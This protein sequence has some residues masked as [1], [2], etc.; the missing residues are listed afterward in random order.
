MKNS[1]KYFLNNLSVDSENY[2]LHYFFD[3]ENFNGNNYIYNNTE[4]TDYTGTY[5]GSNLT[6][7]L[8]K[9]TGYLFFDT[10]N[11]VNIPLKDLELGSY[12]FIVNYEKTGNGPCVLF[13]NLNTGIGGQYYGFNVCISDYNNLLIEYY[14]VN[15]NLK[16]LSPTY[17]LDTKGIVSFRGYENNI[18]I[19]YYNA[20]YD[21][22][23]T[24]AFE[25]D[26]NS[27]PNVTGSIVLGSGKFSNFPNYSGYIRDFILI[28]DNITNS[29][30]NKIIDQFAFN[31][32]SYY[33]FQRNNEFYG[34]EN[35]P[36]NVTH[37]FDSYVD[38]TG[39]FNSGFLDNTGVIYGSI[40]GSNYSLDLT[41]NSGVADVLYLERRPF[42]SLKNKIKKTQIFAFTNTLSRTS[43]VLLNDGTI[44]GWGRNSF[45][46]LS[47]SIDYIGDWT[48][49]PVGKLTNIQDVSCNTLGCLALKND[50]TVTGWGWNY[51]GGIYGTIVDNDP[52]SSIFTGNYNNTPLSQLT[53]ISGISMGQYFSVFLKN[54]GTVL[55]WGANNAGQVA[56]INDRILPYPL[57]IQITGIYSDW[58][59]LSGLTL[60]YT[61]QYNSKPA[62]KYTN[63]LENFGL[64]LYNNTTGWILDY[65]G[66]SD[67][68]NLTGNVTPP[69]L[70]NNLN[71]PYQIVVENSQETAIN[72]LYTYD[73]SIYEKNDNISTVIG[74]N[75]GYG[76]NVWGVQY[77]GDIVYFNSGIGSPSLFP[78]T[79]WSG[80]NEFDYYGDITIKPKYAQLDYVY[81]SDSE[82]RFT[83]VFE[84]TIVG[85]LTGIKKISAGTFHVYA[86]KNDN[87]ITGWGNNQYYQIDPYNV[88]TMW[89]GNWNNNKLNLLTGVS[90][91]LANSTA[92]LVLFNNN[93]ISGWGGI[94]AIGLSG[95]YLTGVKQIGGGS[96]FLNALL[97]NEILTGWGTNTGAY[98][99][100]ASGV[101]QYNSS[102]FGTYYEYITG[103]QIKNLVSGNAYF[104][105]NIEVER[106]TIITET[107]TTIVSQISGY[108]NQVLFSGVTGYNTGWYKDIPDFCGTGFPL[109]LV[110]GIIGVITGD[111]LTGIDIITSSSSSQKIVLANQTYQTGFSSGIYNVSKTGNYIYQFSYTN[112]GSSIDGLETLY[113][114]SGYHTLQSKNILVQNNSLIATKNSNLQY[115]K[116]YFLTRN[117]EFLQDLGVDLLLINQYLDAKDIIEIY[118]FQI[119]SGLNISLNNGLSMSKA[120]KDFRFDATGLNYSVNLNGVA[121]TTGNNYTIS[122]INLG[123]PVSLYEFNDNLEGDLA[124]TGEVLFNYTGQTGQALSK[125]DFLYLNGQKLISGYQYNFGSTTIS[126]ITG[127]IPVTGLVHGFNSLIN[128]IRYTGNMYT[129]DLPRFSK[130]SELIW[131]NGIKLRS[132]SYYEISENDKFYN[133]T[134]YDKSPV[135]IYNNTDNYFNA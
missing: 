81:N 88:S 10:T 60:N 28:D 62:Y 52:F 84:E 107:I 93:T 71:L 124:K 85:Q 13:S 94:G 112:N 37:V 5:F 23:Y 77:N 87:T 50:G 68:I 61:G 24:E 22:F 56:G 121:Q 105:Y 49:C 117:I 69:P 15:K 95:N 89:T 75:G 39:C 115:T 103:Q 18:F 104:V 111:V 8:N 6:T 36:D 59:Y 86:L 65:S 34:Y 100:I 66:L 72:G 129:F 20:A 133:P 32:N 67:I 134:F 64:S 135:T 42:L 110:S 21:D 9:K 116:N 63:D 108:E 99:K 96:A 25:I 120:S 83:G 98:P 26:N 43:I 54:D 12:T 30:L 7:N 127:N 76:A 113:L 106:P 82:N 97:Q 123:S 53:D 51:L 16:Y 73:G 45:G 126:F 38:I 90:D 128:Y 92:G 3:S 29:Q 11:R 55:S 125:K 27:T 14:D 1:T 80:N 31:L 114:D 102:Q 19:N 47:G 17:N 79:G 48:G 57:K 118:L 40:T 44:T 74:N 101:K 130:N 132:D 33:T 70:S 4:Y 2:I 35:Y 41:G 58:S 46:Q 91:V 131:L 78:L 109:Y 122:N 119:N